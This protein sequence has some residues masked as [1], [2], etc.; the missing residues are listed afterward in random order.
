MTP[1]EEDIREE[2][3]AK[4]ALANA[5]IKEAEFNGIIIDLENEVIEHQ[6]GTV[7]VGNVAINSIEIEE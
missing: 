5:I 3:I 7:W 6:L 4:I 1:R 2:D